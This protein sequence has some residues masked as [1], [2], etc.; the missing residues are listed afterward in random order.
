M[1]TFSQNDE[2][3]Q[4]NL[5]IPNDRPEPQPQVQSARQEKAESTLSN[6][7]RLMR[8]LGAIAL[9]ASGVAFLFEGWHSLTNF[10][11]Y[12][13]FSGFLLA[14]GAAGVFC[15]RVIGEN[16]GARSF[17]SLA[18][19]GVT[20]Q[21]AQLGALTYALVN[22]SSTDLKALMLYEATGVVALASMLGVFL[23]LLMPVAG[24]GFAAL[25][26]SQAR[27]ATGLFLGLCS[28]L[29][30]PTR[31][32]LHAL[33]LGAAGAFALVW[34][35]RK[36]F[37]HDPAMATTEG[38]IL[39]G[40]LAGPV[41]TILG[42]ELFYP[43]SPLA[44]GLFMLVCGTGLFL[45]ANHAHVR[46]AL[47][48]PAQALCFGL[49][50][51]GWLQ[52]CHAVQSGAPMYYLPLAWA[53]IG[54]SF[55]S[56]GGGRNYRS[57]GALGTVVGCVIGLYGSSNLLV[58]STLVLNGALLVAMAFTVKE[59]SILRSGMISF[60]MGIAVALWTA[61]LAVEWSSWIGLAVSG[62][63][64]LLA[65]S[66]IERNRERLVGVYGQIRERTQQW[67]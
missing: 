10:G 12:G 27:F 66:Y 23:V 35:D 15:S 32:D 58:A 6:F 19:A 28:F 53:A 65:S 31:V 45:L 44:S 1:Q 39:R 61:A 34:A 57:L 24:L 20:V 5:R 9:V 8:I 51:M 43:V 37:R 56:E 11:K 41:V 16:K 4:T 30:V 60:A 40:I 18:A 49:I 14:L 3:T 25:A 64:V 36:V 59:L 54:L 46:K 26:R 7:P 13:A 62:A 2:N 42:R 17:L 21:A 29:L 33:A 52:V 50:S 67:N 55:Y 47:A 38:W 22:P 63:T 48:L